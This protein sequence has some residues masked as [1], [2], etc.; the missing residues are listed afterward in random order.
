MKN[1][2]KFIVTVGVI[3]AFV[4]APLLSALA[5]CSFAIAITLLAAGLVYLIAAALFSIVAT[6]KL[7]KQ[8]L[9]LS[10]E[11]VH[12]MFENERSKIHSDVQS[13]KVKVARLVLLSRLYALSLVFAALLVATG[14]VA[15]IAALSPITEGDM[16]DFILADFM[17]ALAFYALFALEPL[18][19]FMKSYDRGAQC[20][21]KNNLLAEVSY[22]LLYQTARRAAD[23]V[24]F[25]GVFG[26]AHNL[27][28]ENIAVMEEPF[29]IILL[30]PLCVDLLTR[31]EL[32]Q[33]FLHEFAHVVENDTAFSQTL[34]AVRNAFD[35][36]NRT[37][38]PV[39]K[40]LFF[41]AIDFKLSMQCDIYQRFSSLLREQ[42]ADEAI[43]KHGNP[44]HFVNGEVKTLLLDRYLVE[45]LATF[46]FRLFA[47]EQPPTD[48][49]EQL[50]NAFLAWLPLYAEREL[51]RLKN[52]LPSRSDTHPTLTMRMQAAACETYDYSAVEP[53]EA[54][55]AE[56]KKLLLECNR[57][58]ASWQDW[59]EARE[60][61]YLPVMER[62]GYFESTDDPDDFATAHALY[63]YLNYD[64]EKAEAVAD[65]V[66]SDDC[67]NPP[68]VHVKGIAL[69]IRYD[70]QA[71]DYLHRAASSATAVAENAV[72]LYGDA[73]LESGDEQLVEKM[74]SEQAQIQ[75]SYIDMQLA[76]IRFGKVTSR[77]LRPTS[78][79]EEY[80]G[81]MKRAIGR[82]C[83]SLLNSVML[84]GAH[85]K[86][87]SF[88]CLFVTPKIGVDLQAVSRLINELDSYLCY[89]DRRDRQFMIVFQK[90]KTRNKTLLTVGTELL[91]K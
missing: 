62:I 47:N 60:D 43:L 56:T 61:G 9:N 68:A 77:S 78:L 31:D 4:L 34:F 18:A 74:R 29:V 15:A 83:P 72:P 51:L 39:T 2:L 36:Q 52:T 30:P 33:V 84:C 81:R 86:G 6:L 44:Q 64:M 65:K 28:N 55:R 85:K 16:G 88:E 7:K 71:L 54:Y 70:R 53:D 22:P 67:D 79:S 82:V 13:A 73:V 24:G 17:L 63:D 49:Y 46:N 11:N 45:A 23:M 57:V 89:L 14:T 41:S 19:T 25:K 32:F 8:V 10:I 87:Y 35:V 38:L 58:R 75:Q 37:L 69:Y 90:P 21:Q 12:T 3:S 48:Y 76:R 40:K 59:K 26:L 5:G 42:H 50:K 66:L 80:V 20:P 91:E 1:S 27:E